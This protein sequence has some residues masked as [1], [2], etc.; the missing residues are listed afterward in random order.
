MDFLPD[1][2]VALKNL[3]SLE[4]LGTGLQGVPVGIGNLCQKP[5]RLSPY[6][7]EKGEGKH[8]KNTRQWSTLEELGPLL[9]LRCLLLENLKK[10]FHSSVARAVGLMEKSHLIVLFFAALAAG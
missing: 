10:A 4:I 3:R 9:L 1:S 8:T 5:N 7:L 6:S 2:V